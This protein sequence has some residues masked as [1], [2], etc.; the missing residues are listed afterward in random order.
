MVVARGPETHN[1][2]KQTLSQPGTTCS[3]LPMCPEGAS[4]SETA[5]PFSKPNHPHHF[6]L[7]IIILLAISKTALSGGLSQ[8]LREHKQSWHLHIT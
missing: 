7:F 1:S 8:H 2:A 6:F 4:C 3:A 5:I